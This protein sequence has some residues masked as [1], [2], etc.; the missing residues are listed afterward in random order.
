LRRSILNFV[1]SFDVVRD[2]CCPSGINVDQV[3]FEVALA[4]EFAVVLS[5][6]FK[7]NMDAAFKDFRNAGGYRKMVSELQWS[8]ELDV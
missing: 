6:H 4:A 7:L 8:N 1:K 5:I 3:A 2:R